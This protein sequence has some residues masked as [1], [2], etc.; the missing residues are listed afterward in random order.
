MILKR[1]GCLID[2]QIICKSHEITKGIWLT[3]S[4]HRAS[5]HLDI[6][7]GIY[8]AGET[9]KL[10]SDKTTRKRQ[11]K[12]FTS[13]LQNE[14]KIRYKVFTDLS[15]ARGSV[16]VLVVLWDIPVSIIIQSLPKHRHVHQ[17]HHPP[18]VSRTGGTSADHQLVRSQPLCPPR[19]SVPLS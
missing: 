18:T 17:W 14:I 4:T 11:T 10:D 2:Q 13:E 3:Q 19:L 1:V 9:C 12:L 16:D 6:G 15:A 7:L 5:V 8:W